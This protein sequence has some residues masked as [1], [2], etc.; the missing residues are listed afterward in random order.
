M[1]DVANPFTARA[2]NALII[3]KALASAVSRKIPP[4]NPIGPKR[5]NYRLGVVFAAVTDNDQL[6]RGVG[7]AQNRFD[8]GSNVAA[9]PIGG[10]DDGKERI[11]AHR[12]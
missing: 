3:G 8:R 5:G 12:R 10:E 2:A 6:E 9:A 11:I 1:A 4:R 7:L